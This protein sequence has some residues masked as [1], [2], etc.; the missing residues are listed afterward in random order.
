MGKKRG[1]GGREGG[2]QEGIGEEGG[3]PKYALL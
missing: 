1:E 2:D 3:K